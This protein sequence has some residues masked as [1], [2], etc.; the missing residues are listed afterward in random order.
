MFHRAFQ[1]SL[2]LSFSFLAAGIQAYGGTDYLIVEKVEHLLVY[3]K[4]QQET[5]AN[6]LLPFA[7]LKIINSNDLLGDGFTRCMKIDF[8]GEVFYLLKDKDGRLIRSGPLGFEKF[9]SNCSSLFDTV[10]ILSGN[11]NRLSPINSASSR[12]PV[13]EK[14]V[15]LFRHRNETYCRTLSSPPMYGWI[16]F[17]AG[18]EGKDWKVMKSVPSDHDSIPLVVAQKIQ[19]QLDETNQVLARLFDH[20]NRETHQQ[21]Q[22]PRWSMETSDK[23]VLCT[24]QG[25][26]PAEVFHQST[27]YLVKDINNILLGTNLDVAYT[28]GRVDIRPR[29]TR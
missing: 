14:V 21:R 3:N 16:D 29:A 7:P 8:N 23:A 26:F 18:K 5:A 20:F 15:R 9:F 22:A 2:R 12:L 1:R 13:S 6:V 11:S 17:T 27:Q 24:L 4:Y 28:T 19:D 25:D 10:Q